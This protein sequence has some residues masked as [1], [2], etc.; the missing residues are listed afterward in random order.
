MKMNKLTNY[1]VIFAVMLQLSGCASTG[2]TQLSKV[3]TDNL[4]NILV[5]GETTLVA[6][7]QR[8]GD[9]SDVDFDSKGNKKWTYAHTK[10]TSKAINFVP[11]VNYFK[12]GTDNV[13]KKLVIIFDQNDTVVDYMATQSK[14]E[15][16]LGILG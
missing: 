7:K 10:M 1:G 8:F 5:K 12:N 14:G 16:K 11:I 13:T 4:S 9:P 3:N 15:T 2:N 6:V